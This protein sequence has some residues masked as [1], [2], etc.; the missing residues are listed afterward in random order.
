VCL[1]FDIC[2]T[3][4]ILIF[5]RD[6]V[7]GEKLIQVFRGASLIKS[8]RQKRKIACVLKVLQ[9]HLQY[10]KEDLSRR[11]VGFFLHTLLKV[12]ARTWNRQDSTFSRHY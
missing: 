1:P 4:R 2:R 11:K 6:D 7:K 12:R 5:L 10:A 8:H 9:K 3:R